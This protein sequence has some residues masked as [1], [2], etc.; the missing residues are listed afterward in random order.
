LTPLNVAR[1]QTFD[2]ISS[3]L[4]EMTGGSTSQPNQPS[5]LFPDN[6][7][8][9]GGDEVNTT[10]WGEVAEISNWLQAHNMTQ[11]QG[12]A[13][14]VN[15]AAEIAISQGRRPVQWSEGTLLDLNSICVRVVCQSLVC[16]NE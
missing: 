10:C 5:G 6:F 14:F 12:Y 13:Y 2:F 4:M 3:L 9:L 15:K 1:P 8:H 7:I 16:L 11:D